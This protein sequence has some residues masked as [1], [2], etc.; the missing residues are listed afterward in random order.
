[1]YGHVPN[2]K[3]KYADPDKFEPFRGILCPDSRIYGHV[4]EEKYNC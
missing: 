3:Q 4:P 1:M 2:A